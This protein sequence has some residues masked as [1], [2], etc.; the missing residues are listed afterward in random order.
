VRRS[1]IADDGAVRS[2][3]FMTD[4]GI[5]LSPTDV[6]WDGTSA[7]QEAQ[8]ILYERAIDE[9][10]E[11]IAVS[12]QDGRWIVVTQERA[13]RHGDEGLHVYS[14]SLTDKHAIWLARLLGRAAGAIAADGRVVLATATGRLMVYS[15]GGDPKTNEGVVAVDVPLDP[16]ASFVS[17][18]APGFVALATPAAGTT[19]A[20]GLDDAG[21]VVWKADVPFAAKQ[22]AVDGGDGR[23]YVVGNGLAALRGGAVLWSARSDTPM[24][25][26]AFADGSLA[27]CVGALLRILDA[28]GHV[29]AELPTPDRDA[30]LTP[31]AIGPDGAVWVATRK[32]VLVAR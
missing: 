10:G 29:K 26:T 14:A 31:P 12:L 24:S 4:T 16:P 18:I 7:T 25:A 19:H 27:V 28:E 2:L 5:I 1:A 15:A 30:I 6:R 21:K 32:S 23:T 9:E 3:P 8:R 17:A 13:T 11:Q 22:P 20:T